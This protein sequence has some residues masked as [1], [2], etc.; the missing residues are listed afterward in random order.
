MKNKESRDSLK[1]KVN[2]LI[3]KEK[4]REKEK[5]E[6]AKASLFLFG[7]LVLVA[8]FIVCATIFKNC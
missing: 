5:E 4:R 6:I 7:M 2:F 1:K 8:C 3:E